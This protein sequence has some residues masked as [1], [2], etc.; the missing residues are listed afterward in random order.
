VGEGYTGQGLGNYAANVF[1]TFNSQNFTA[2]RGSGGLLGGF[3]YLNDQLVLNAGYGIDAPERADLALDGI[4]RNEAWYTNLFWDVTRTVQLGFQVDYRQT[5]YVALPD[6]SAMV[7][8]T[9]FLW[10]F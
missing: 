10:R 7:F 1:Q 9:Q 5:D 6:N 3:W 8:Y 2:V 4:A